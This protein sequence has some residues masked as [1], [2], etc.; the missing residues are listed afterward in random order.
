[1][2]LYYDIIV[3]YYDILY[4]QQSFF[5]QNHSFINKTKQNFAKVLRIEKHKL[6]LRVLDKFGPLHNVIMGCENVKKIPFQPKLIVIHYNVIVGVP[7]PQNRVL[8]T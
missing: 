8:S 1:M 3:T 5:Y 4:V 2:T 7:I 6:F